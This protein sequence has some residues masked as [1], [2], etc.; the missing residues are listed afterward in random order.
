MEQVEIYRQA[1][2]FAGWPANYGMW[3]WGDELVLGF[4]VGAH[5]TEGRFHAR[6]TA[7]PFINLQAR[8]LDGGRSWS[9]GDFPGNLPGGR[10]LSA[11]EHMNAG[12]R[13]GEI[14]DETPLPAL[15]EA[16]DFSHPGFRLDGGTHGPA[17]RHA[18]LALL[19][20]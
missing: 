7:K 8:S 4:T 14:L 17:R 16:L 2:R 11:D 13:L 3:G 20:L 18:L 1:G 9:V 5:L 15:T 19:F 12:L 6:D 10:G